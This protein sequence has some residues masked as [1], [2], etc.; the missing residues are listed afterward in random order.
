M[1]E[2]TIT[3]REQKS[4]EGRLSSMSLICVPLSSL[5][6]K[7]NH[8]GLLFIFAAIGNLDR[9]IDVALKSIHRGPNMLFYLEQLVDAEFEFGAIAVFD[10]G[11]FL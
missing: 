5:Q 9:G 1:E 7:R 3:I 11:V 4:I 10:Q 8:E 2:P 6:L